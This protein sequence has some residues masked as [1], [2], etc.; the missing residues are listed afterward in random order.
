MLDGTTV[1]FTALT[2][3]IIHP[4]CCVLVYATDTTASNIVA[5]R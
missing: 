1:T 2:A 4:I 5:L 3:G